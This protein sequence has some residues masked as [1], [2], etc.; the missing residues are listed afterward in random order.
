[1]S[2]ETIESIVTFS[3]YLGIFL[4]MIGNGVVSFPSSQILY[5]L[6]G[7]FVFTGHLNFA[8]V[9][10]AGSLGNT[11]GN[12]ILYELARSKGLAYLLRWKIFPER[13]VKKVRVAFNKKG[14]WFLF[15]GKLLPAIKVFVPIPA[16]I[17]KMD[18][19][20]YTIIV[21][22]SSAL[23]TFPFLAV[24]YY[25]GKSAHVF[26][27]YAVVLLLIALVV[28]T[29]FYKFMNSEEVISEVEG[30]TKTPANK[31]S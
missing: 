13:E 9:V 15:V 25:F 24:G 26:G 22:I 31:S 7:Y 2:H 30:I 12:I 3:G 6:C 5:I 19:L 16:G 14:T 21:A 4:L 20:T 23:W 27:I 1:M 10:L 18:R 17:A 28:V 11:I 8:L 29:L